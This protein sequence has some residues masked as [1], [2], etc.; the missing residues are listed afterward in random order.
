MGTY[1]DSYPRLSYNPSG[2]PYKNRTS[3]TDVTFRL[4]MRDRIKNTLFSYYTV[5]ISDDDTME[6][7]A[8]KYYGSPE[9]HWVIALAN[10]IIDPQYDW[11]LNYR[12]YV[13]YI[14]KKYGSVANAELIPHHYEKVIRRYHQGTKTTYEE[15]YEI[16]Q[17]TYDFLPT[18][19]FRQFDLVD[20][21]TVE[22]TITTRIIS[23]SQ[24]EFDLNNKKK[25]M[26][27]IKKEY[28]GNILDEFAG[29]TS[30]NG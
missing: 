27:I 25:Q 12:S 24:Y 11:P 30:T 2:S 21:T 8:A 20:G 13:S 18:Y 19:A 6:I 1:F 17:D 3:I 15:V 28:L 10:D 14:T 29:L 16:Q 9:F 4:K 26:K 7:L 23:A 22:E 5:D